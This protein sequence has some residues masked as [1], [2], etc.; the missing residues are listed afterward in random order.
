MRRAGRGAALVLVLAAAALLAPALRG[1]AWLDGSNTVAPYRYLN[2]PADAAT[3]DP[4]SGGSQSIGLSATGSDPGQ[5][6]TDD[7]QAE[8]SLLPGA[9][10][11]APGE[12][13]VDFTLTPVP[14]AVPPPAGVSLAANVYRVQ[15][16]YHNS[17][18]PIPVPFRATVLIGL[19]YGARHPNA[20]YRLDGTTWT[21]LT[22]RVFPT[23]FTLDAPTDRLGDFV[24]AAA[25]EASPA[26]PTP[27]PAAGG[28]ASQS[29][30]GVLALAGILGVL[31]VAAVAALIVS[32]RRRA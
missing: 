32:K 19:R 12:D 17:Q 26:T 24:P 7:A 3:T 18:A 4:P 15:A 22:S 16:K 14:P 13:A 20:I 31:V 10:P 23:T 5:V 6:Y 1:P 11:A 21:R 9:I 29:N 28:G 30:G 25:P 2:P 27:T 8:L